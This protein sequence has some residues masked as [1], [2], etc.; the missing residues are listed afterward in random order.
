MLV[1]YFRTNVTLKSYQVLLVSKDA[2][3]KLNSDKFNEINTISVF[4]I[5]T[6]VHKNL[7]EFARGRHA[8]ESR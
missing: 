8:V 5:F 6:N 7:S 3:T 2:T 1:R 4:E